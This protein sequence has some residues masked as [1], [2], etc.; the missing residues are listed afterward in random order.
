MEYIIVTAR[1]TDDLQEVVMEYIQDGFRPVGG[2]L[3]TQN[4]RG[5]PSQF[6]Q[7][8]TKE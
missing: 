8:M 4:D 1:S 5:T 7:A 6:G 2:P 3:V